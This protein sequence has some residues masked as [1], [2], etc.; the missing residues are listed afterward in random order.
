MTTKLTLTIEKETIKRAKI[1][2]KGTQ[3]SLSEMV[4]SYLES[5]GTIEQKEDMSPIMKN[6]L[7]KISKKSLVEELAGS[8]KLPENY[9][10]EELDN[11]KREYLENKYK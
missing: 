6:L 10:D 8:L 9:T 1:Y 11:I 4:Q 2:A 3:R 7:D 5:L